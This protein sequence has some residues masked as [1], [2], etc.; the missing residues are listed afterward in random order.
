MMCGWTVRG[1]WSVDG[2]CV[3]IG[4]WMGCVWMVNK[5]TS[6]VYGQSNHG[7]GPLNLV[8]NFI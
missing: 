4:A 1:Y 7:I 6:D 2:Y 5:G 8:L 3:D